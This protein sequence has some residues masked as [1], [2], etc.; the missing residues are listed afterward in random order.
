MSEGAIA[1]CLK[2][3]PHTARILSVFLKIVI[4]KSQVTSA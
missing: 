2:E 1:Q 4:A 3:I